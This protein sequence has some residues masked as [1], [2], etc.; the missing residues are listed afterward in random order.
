MA[1]SSP[2]REGDAHAHAHAHD[3][4]WP[5]PQACDLLATRRPSWQDQLASTVEVSTP[6]GTPA[7]PLLCTHTG[8]ATTT[9]PLSPRLPASPKIQVHQILHPFCSG[10]TFPAVNAAAPSQPTPTASTTPTTTRP[11][12][13][14]HHLHSNSASVSHSNNPLPAV[15]AHAYPALRSPSAVD[16]VHRALPSPSPLNPAPSD[17]KCGNLSHQL[18]ALALGTCQ[19]PQPSPSS[20]QSLQSLPSLLQAYPPNPQQ[21]ASFQNAVPQPSPPPTCASPV[22]IAPHPVAAVTNN[23]TP[24]TTASIPSAEQADA[25]EALIT[26]SGSQVTFVSPFISAAATGGLKPSNFRPAHDDEPPL[27]PRN[28][29][30]PAPLPLPPHRIESQRASPAAPA[31]AEES[32]S[33]SVKSTSSSLLPPAFLSA[34]SIGSFSGES[35]TTSS[36]PTPSSAASHLEPWSSPFEADFNAARPTAPMATPSSPSLVELEF[37]PQLPSP[38]PKGLGFSSA[39]PADL[40]NGPSS[41]TLV[42]AQKPKHIRR[43]SVDVG[44]L[45]N[46][47]GHQR[48]GRTAKQD[49]PA[50]AF[51][52]PDQL[53]AERVQRQVL[54]RSESQ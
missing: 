37:A 43:R 47:R 17:T 2:E 20:K 52:P 49:A 13:T 50:A 31:A 42:N 26:S 16:R 32:L 51:V 5:C 35:S 22:V 33:S 14:T 21:L 38:L 25:C 4:D 53:K 45:V 9:A 27:S 28:N 10:Y 8:T 23:A 19:H 24:V 44:T 18:P 40:S 6:F 36:I 39:H 12:T 11:P 41:A 29:H 48:H 3:D 7:S 34:R 30:S 15:L 1:A 54:Q 46:A